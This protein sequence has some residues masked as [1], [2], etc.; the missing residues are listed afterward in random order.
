MIEEQISVGRDVG[1]C[2]ECQGRI[3]LI[4]EV[5]RCVDCGKHFRRKK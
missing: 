1:E 3:Y 5:Q 2:D 4:G